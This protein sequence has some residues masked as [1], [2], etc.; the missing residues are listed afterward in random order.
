MRPAPSTLGRDPGPS[1]TAEGTLTP[2]PLAAWL[3]RP[4]P[5]AARPAASSNLGLGLRYLGARG[6]SLPARGGWASRGGVRGT[7][8]GR[9]TW[10]QGV[11]WPLGRWHGRAGRARALG[12]LPVLEGG[13]PTLGPTLGS[14]ARSQPVHN[15]A[16]GVAL[17]GTGSLAGRRL[18]PLLHAGRARHA[19][20]CVV[21]NPRR[22]VFR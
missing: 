11:P 2:A 20:S 9:R 3:P 21:V 14:T 15:A 12:L 10:P 4:L 6:G 16:R 17:R 19:A 18:A 22:S 5:R 8:G 1:E 7:P 13:V